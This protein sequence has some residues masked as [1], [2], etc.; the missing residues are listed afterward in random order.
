METQVLDKGFVKLVDFLDGDKGI[1]D[2]ARVSYGG[3]S[4]GEEADRKL[5]T[6]LLRNKHMSP[7]EHAVFKFHIKCP[8]FV[9]RQ[10]F[11]HRMASYNEISYRYTESKDEF[12]LPTTWRGQDK[13]NKQGSIAA[14]E[15]NQSEAYM[16]A[17]FHSTAA[18]MAYQ[19]LLAMGVA[20]EQARIVLPVNLYTQFYWTVN[21]R[22]LMNFITLRADAHAQLEIQEY[23]N[24]LSTMFEAKMPWTFSAFKVVKPAAEVPVEAQS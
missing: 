1:V 19:K 8:I 15:I 23:A 14:P 2:A 6:Y 17:E 3:K 18:F 10:W 22:S 21:A 7:F 16:V 5:L 9:A 11:R 12:Y 4:K 24:T 13:K 20:R